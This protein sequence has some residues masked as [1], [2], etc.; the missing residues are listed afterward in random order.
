M[1]TYILKLIVT[2]FR[3]I[4]GISFAVPHGHGTLGGAAAVR[5]VL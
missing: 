2:G 1:H 5:P 4:V 3:F